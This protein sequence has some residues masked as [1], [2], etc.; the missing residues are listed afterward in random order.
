MGVALALCARR[1]KKDPYQRHV[2]PLSC[3]WMEYYRAPLFYVRPCCKKSA[4]KEMNEICDEL[5]AAHEE[6]RRLCF[7]AP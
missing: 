6:R 4:L 5:L 3:W 7:Y 1:R 2:L